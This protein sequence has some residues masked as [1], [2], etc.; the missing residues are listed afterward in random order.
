MNDVVLAGV[1]G[2]LRRRLLARGDES[3]TPSGCCARCRCGRERTPAPRQPGVGDV[4][5]AAGRRAGSR[6][7]AWRRS[8]RDRTP[9][10]AGA[11]RRRRVPPRPHPVRRAHACSASRPASSTASRSSTSSSPTCPARRCRSTASGRGCSRRTRWCRCRGTSASGSRSSRTAVSCTSGSSPTPT[12]VRISTSSADDVE[13][14]FAELRHA[15]DHTTSR[16]GG[17]RMTE[18]WEHDAWDCADA[19]RAGE[20]RPT[21]VLEESLDADRGAE[22]RAE[23]GLLPRRRSARGRGPRRSTP[24]SPAVRTRDRSPAC[25]SE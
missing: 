12:F 17:G 10:G 9:Q 5:G 22:R 2:A 7:A 6:R 15:A 16:P 20:V 18:L 4:R 19:V 25:R 1:A 8:G 21:A 24:R 11:G 3:R 13:A 23:R 14:A